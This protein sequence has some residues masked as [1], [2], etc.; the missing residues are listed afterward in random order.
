MAALA[1]ERVTRVARMATMGEMASGL[2]HELNQPLTAITTYARACER[3]LAM[4]EPDFSELQL[5]VREIG[6][7]GMR[8][9]KIIDRLR[10]LVKSD[11]PELPEALDINSVVEELRTLLEIDARLFA[12]RIEFS[13]AG[14]LPRVDGNAVQLQQLLLNLVRNSF[15]ALAEVHS[16]ERVV[17]LA[18]RL[19]EDG[20][21][22]IAVT[23]NGPGF[24]PALIG[25]LFHPFITT[26]KSGTGLGLA[27]S[28]T[29]ALNH[30]GSI[31]IRNQAPPSACVFVRLP[32]REDKAWMP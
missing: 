8:A 5:A 19:S 6:A 14:S 20:Q 22:E 3:F 30:G 18:T 7:E 24:L 27:M 4:P 32:A 28:R 12:A 15:E 2:A 29:I 13:L 16:S 11:E 31:G 17:Q 9:G 1:H 25:R 21:I 23:D 26:K 10:Q